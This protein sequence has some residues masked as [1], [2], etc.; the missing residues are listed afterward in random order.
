MRDSGR[1]AE[2]RSG[3]GADPTIGYG[4]AKCHRP[5]PLS[6]ASTCDTAQIAGMNPITSVRVSRRLSDAP[7]TI[8]SASARTMLVDTN[9][10][11]MRLPSVVAFRCHAIAAARDA[12]R[13][14]VE[15]FRVHR[16]TRGRSEAAEKYERVRP[17]TVHVDGLE[18]QRRGLIVRTVDVT[19]RA[20]SVSRA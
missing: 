8:P 5:R 1:A 19:R 7:A 13:M 10:I 16:S 18:P 6:R 17:V 9:A 11:L 15:P 14:Q 2:R 12:S 4:A 20:G 3:R